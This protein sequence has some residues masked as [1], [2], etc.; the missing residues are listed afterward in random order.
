M[1]EGAGP[2]LPSVQECLKADQPNA[3]A[4]PYSLKDELQIALFKDP[5]RTAL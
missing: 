5:V 2:T 4:L 3:A 1:P